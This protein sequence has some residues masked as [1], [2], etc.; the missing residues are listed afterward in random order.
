MSSKRIGTDTI[1]FN[2]PPVFLSWANSGG[3]MEAKG[4][5]SGY[6]DLLETDSFRGEKT[7]E[8]AE[9]AMQIQTLERALGKG[10]LKPSELSLVFGGD[11]LNQCTGTS[12]AMRHWGLP[13]FGV[14]SACASMGESLALAAMSIAGGTAHSA[15]AIASSHYCTAE[16]QYRTPM[17]YGNQR[18]PSAQ[19]TATACGCCILAAEGSGPRITHAVPG[20]VTDL[21]ITDANNMGAA[22]APEDVKLAP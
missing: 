18:T 13:F 15:A 21:G 8:L 19:W 5:L 20:R 7:W 16:R 12:Y 10:R 2:R 1:R 11:L 22:M 6:F 4:P 17:P 3:K 14:Y 9:T